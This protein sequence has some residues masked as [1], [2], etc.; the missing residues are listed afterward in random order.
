MLER[1]EAV[2]AG[3]GKDRRIQ[4]ISEIKTYRTDGRAI[5]YAAAQS[6]R[7]VIETAPRG[8]KIPASRRVRLRVPE[9]AI[10]EVTGSGEN[11]AH[12]VEYHSADIL[13]RKRYRQRRRPNLE[14]VYE[15]GIATQGE[16]GLQIAGAGLV[17]AK[18]AK[19]VTAAGQEAFRQRNKVCGAEGVL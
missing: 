19:R 10:G 16:T 18:A 17:D 4:V 7:H 2:L 13:A 11:I 12:V 6:L 3:Y 15:K 8:D 9:K 5:T 1:I 14:V